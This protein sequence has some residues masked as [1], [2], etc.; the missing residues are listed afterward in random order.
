MRCSVGRACPIR[1]VRV[2]LQKESASADS[3]DA[4]NTSLSVADRQDA[5]TKG[6]RFLTAATTIEADAVFV[7]CDDRQER[8]SLSPRMDRIP[9]ADGHGAG[10][11]L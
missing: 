7:R 3:L 8:G 10:F 11:P 2:S 6:G 9:A 5:S 4:S 1:S